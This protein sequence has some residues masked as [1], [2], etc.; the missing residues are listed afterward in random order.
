VIIIDR[1]LA[2]NTNMLKKIKFE[3]ED[4]PVARDYLDIL[5]NHGDEVGTRGW[6]SNLARDYCEIMAEITGEEQNIR[7]IHPH[8]NRILNHKGNCTLQSF[9][10]IAWI[11]GFKVQLVPRREDRSRKAA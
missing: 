4:P 8:L 7:S 1:Q 2:K 3:H 5:A 10:V 6:K 9:L 11:L